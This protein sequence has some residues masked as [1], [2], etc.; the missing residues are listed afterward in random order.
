MKN[1]RIGYSIRAQLRAQYITSTNERIK[2]YGQ[3]PWNGKNGSN[4][5]QILHPHRCV[6]DAHGVL[7]HFTQIWNLNWAVFRIACAPMGRI[8]CVQNSLRNRTVKDVLSNAC[9]HSLTRI[10]YVNKVCWVLQPRASGK[11]TSATTPYARRERP[12]V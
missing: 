8:H 5:K 7:R 10:Q 12:Q 4:A 9:P 6:S 1:R 3:C 2:A 11:I